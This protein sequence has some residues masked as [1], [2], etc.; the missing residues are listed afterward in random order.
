M[1]SSIQLSS[2]SSWS[3]LNARAPSTPYPPALLTAATTSRQCENAN[4][5]NSM[6]S[7][8]QMGVR[9]FDLRLS[10]ARRPARL[11]LS[12]GERAEEAA[13]GPERLARH[14]AHARAVQQLQRPRLLLGFRVPPD[15]A[16][17]RV[18]E[19]LAGRGMERGHHRGGRRS[20]IDAVQPDTPADQVGA[21]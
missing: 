9:M 20:G 16:H 18:D 8:S 5:G 17:G 10:V 13:V 1:C 6:P 11:E 7:R 3:G 14:V 15:R 2:I 4:N 19:V 12:G 21:A